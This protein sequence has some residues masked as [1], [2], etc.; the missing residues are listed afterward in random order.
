MSYIL[1]HE[2]RVPVRLKADVIVAGG[3]PAGLA[4]ALAAARNGRKQF[5][6]SVTVF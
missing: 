6:S 2:R 1:E 4:A 3:G 5:S